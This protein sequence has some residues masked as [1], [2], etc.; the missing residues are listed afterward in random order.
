MSIHAKFAA[1]PPGLVLTA[2]LFVSTGWAAS[3]EIITD[4]P[5]PPN[6]VE[7]APPPR[8]GYVW[9][10]G[11]WEWNRHSYVWVSGTWI[12]EHR[13]AHWVPDRWEQ[14]GVQWRFEPGHW[15]H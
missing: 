1:F 6:R 4:A 11:H 12:V 8:D 15:E 5:P 2:S 14:T 3:S 7:H 13:A 10:P 9:A